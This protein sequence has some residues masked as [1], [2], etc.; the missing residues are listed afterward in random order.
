MNPI[1]T[2]PLTLI[3]IIYDIHDSKVQKD[4]DELI[5]IFLSRYKLGY[6]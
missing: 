3:I 6:K 1:M 4:I 2:L 5:T